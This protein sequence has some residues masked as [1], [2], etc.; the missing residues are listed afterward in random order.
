MAHL[1]RYDTCCLCRGVCVCVCVCVCL[2]TTTAHN[3]AS[4]QVDIRGRLV[5]ASV[6][7]M[8]FVPNAY[9]RG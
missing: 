1:S 6:S 7:K 3:R 4:S 5:D 8:P 9:Y 2:S